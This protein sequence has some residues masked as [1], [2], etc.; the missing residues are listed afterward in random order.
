MKYIKNFKTQNDYDNYVTEG[1]V[2]HLP[3]FTF[4]RENKNVIYKPAPKTGNDFNSDFNED[5][6]Y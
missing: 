2:F 6:G 4:I 3:N 1:N 5:F